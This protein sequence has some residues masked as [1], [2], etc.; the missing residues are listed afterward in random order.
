MAIVMSALVRVSRTDPR[1]C[2]KCKTLND[3]E[4]AARESN[5]IQWCVSVSSTLKTLMILEVFIVVLY[6]AYLIIDLRR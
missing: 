6:F 4:T 3:N 1:I 2:P 5:E